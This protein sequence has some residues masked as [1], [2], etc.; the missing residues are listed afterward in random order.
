[1]ITIELTLS[2]NSA[3]KRPHYG[4]IALSVIARRFFDPAGQRPSGTM[5]QPALF[6]SAGD[7]LPVDAPSDFIARIRDELTATLAQVRAAVA[8]AWKDLTA[9]TLAELRFKSIDGWA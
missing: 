7:V 3:D 1:M 2:R 4:K 8:L 5:R 6:A 9:A